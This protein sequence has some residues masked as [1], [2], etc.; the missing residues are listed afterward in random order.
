MKRAFIVL[1]I[2]SSGTRIMTRILVKMGCIGDWDHKQRW[3]TIEPSEETPIVIRRHYPKER[4][5]SWVRKGNSLIGELLLKGYL[6][7]SIIIIR[8]WNAT[9][10]SQINAPHVKN[11]E[12]GEIYSQFVLQRIFQELPASVPFEV[13]S[14]ESL[15][16]RPHQVLKLMQKR[17]G[18]DPVSTEKLK[19]ISSIIK[20]G[21]AKYYA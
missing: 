9:I 7:Y 10:L 20:D 3:D 18:L 1:G 12:E 16:Q 6:I 14:Y 4:S 8:D 2:P 13:V 17:I 21:N 15:V 11:Y 19:E 5:P